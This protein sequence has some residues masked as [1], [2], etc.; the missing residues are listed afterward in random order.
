MKF[1]DACFITDYIKSACIYHGYCI[2][3]DGE[4]IDPENIIVDDE[5]IRL[6]HNNVTHVLFVNDDE[7]DEGMHCTTED[8]FHRSFVESCSFIKKMDVNDIIKKSLY[9]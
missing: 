2:L 6:V 3:Q 5:G 4:I 9:L 1:E 7:C 8:W